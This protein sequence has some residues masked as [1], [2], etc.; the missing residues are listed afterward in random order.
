M[1]STY[2]P[3]ELDFMSSRTSAFLVQT[4]RKQKL[5]LWILFGTLIAFLVWA[6]V[7]E[8][9]ELAR[10]EGKVIPSG[11]TQIIQNLEGGIIKEILVQ[12]GDPVKKGDI[13][14]RISNRESFS[15]LEEA[16]TT[17][18]ELYARSLRLRNEARNKPF[19]IDPKADANLK[20]YLQNELE[21]YRTNQKQLTNRIDIYRAQSK[22][23][24]SELEEARH[25]LTA[26]KESYRLLKR[27]IEIKEPLVRQGIESEV[28]FLKLK[29]EATALLGDYRST[30]ASLPR[31]RNAIVEIKNKIIE[32]QLN[33]QKNAQLEYTKLVAELERTR[34]MQHSFKD[35]VVRTEVRSPVNGTI[36]QV[37]VNTIGGVIRPGMDLLEIVPTDETLLIEAKVTPSDIA[38]IHP[39]QRATI[40]F[41]A[42]DYSIYGSLEGHVTHISAD[43]IVDEEGESYYLIKVRADTSYLTRNGKKYYIIPGM[44]A[45]VDI[46]TGQ[47]TVLDY[48][49]KPILKA[50]RN[51][52]HER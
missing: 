26:L 31:L 29:R 39:D 52:F 5:L 11:K 36:K 33:Y 43:S 10:G 45:G 35:Q 7:T 21:L 17:Y 50:Q 27:E 19:K 15:S 40:R 51:A 18:N 6:S 20:A 49:V 2:N 22:Q 23:K 14:I 47:K 28:D 13:L 34:S 25:R 32:E 16:Q 38:F 3:D 41:T 1:K 9:D 42:Y 46:F 44:I 12:E 4:S 8:I 24:S 48:L 37:F 30:E